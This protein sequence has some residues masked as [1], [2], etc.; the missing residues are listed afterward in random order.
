MQHHPGG[1]L[2]T[3]RT[4]GHAIQRGEAHGGGAALPTLNR[5]KR[6]TITKMGHNQPRLTKCC[7]LGGQA[8]RD[9]F[10]RQTM[11]AVAQDA[12]MEKPLRQRK[13]CGGMAWRAVKGGLE[14][15]DLRHTRKM[16][17]GGLN[18]SQ[19]M[20]LMQGRE[21]HQRAE[22]RH[23]GIRDHH[24]RAQIP[25]A[26][27]HAVANGANRGAIQQRRERAQN[28]TQRA[29]MPLGCLGGCELAL[30]NARPR[31]IVQDEMRRG[32]NAFH[33]AIK[34]LR[35]YAAIHSKHHEFQQ[36]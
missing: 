12:L 17:R 36:G 10:V 30:R 11:K 1:L 31:G 16:L 22:F 19:I 26:M 3:T 13:T 2:A 5:A 34:A 9:I 21:G 20:R 4:H 15:G 25:P 8:T 23:N 32:A 14:T 7:I 6:S 33:L 28:H 27:H 35:Q 24:R 18:A 29:F